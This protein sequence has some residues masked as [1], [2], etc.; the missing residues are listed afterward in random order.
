MGIV[1]L[2]QDAGTVYKGFA[3]IIRFGLEAKKADI[4]LDDLQNS[5]CVLKLETYQALHDK[6]RSFLSRTPLRATIPAYI[7]V[8]VFKRDAYQEA[9]EYLE[10]TFDLYLSSPTL[11]EAVDASGKTGERRS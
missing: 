5:Y 10:R 2:V 7:A 11:L 3:D 6:Q 9:K 1:Q 4:C 8:R